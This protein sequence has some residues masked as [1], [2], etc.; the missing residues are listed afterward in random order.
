MFKTNPFSTVGL[1]FGAIALLAGIIHFSTGPVS[2]E[3]TIET[4]VAE[5]VVAV[6]K[7]VIS[8]LKGLQIVIPSS[9]PVINSDKVIDIAGISIAIVAIICGFVGGMRREN[10][11]GVS[12]A[13]FFG[14]STLLFHAVLFSI[15]I[16]FGILLLILAIAFLTGSLS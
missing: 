5:K 7:G 3:K 9:P 1:L 2:T 13:L 12:G 8:G 16:I 15:G 11:W 10:R 4:R 6:K 14:A